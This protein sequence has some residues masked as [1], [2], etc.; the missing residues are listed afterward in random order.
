M[1]KAKQDCPGQELPTSALC[2][3]ISYNILISVSSHGGGDL[4]KSAQAQ[5]EVGNFSYL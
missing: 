5:C 3:T 1:G 2:T 4:E